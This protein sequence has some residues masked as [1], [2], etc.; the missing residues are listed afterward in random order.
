V[1]DIFNEPLIETKNQNTRRAATLGVPAI[2]VLFTMFVGWWLSGGTAISLDVPLTN[3]GDGLLILIMIKRVIEGSWLFHSNLMGAPF[4]SNLYDYPIPD[5]GSLFVLKWLG[6]I[7]GS[8]GAALNVYYVLGFPLN[9]LSAYIVLRKLNVSA[10]LSFAGGFIFT[11]L[12][13]HFERLG[14]LF[15]TWYFVAPIFVWYAFKIYR[16]GHTGWGESPHSV[17]LHIKNAVVL[18]V[19][20]CFGVYYAFF[21]VLTFITAGMM[22]YFQTRS[23]NAI[24]GTALAV[25]IVT[26]G[27]I[28]NVTPNLIDRYQNGVNRE[29][30]TRLPVEAEV[31][32]LKIVQLLLPRE[33]HRFAP[34]AKVTAKYSST[35]P[36]V[37]ENRTASLGFIGSIGFVALLLGFF[38]PKVRQDARFFFLAAITLSL[39]LFCTVGGFS[40]L[41]AVLISPM[42]RAWNRVSVFVAFTSIAATMLLIQQS[43]AR[44]W[45][46]RHFVL[47]P[48]AVA[49]TLCLFALWDQTTPPCVPCLRAAS[50]GF[51]SD[52]LFVA[53][54]EKQVP[55]GSAIYQ[56]PYVAFPEVPPVNQLGNYDPGREF[57]GSTTLKWSWGGVKGRAG[58]MFFRA[59]STTPMK[60][61]IEVAR[62]LCF[63]GVTVDRRGYADGGVAVEAQLLQILGKPPVLTGANKQ[64]IFFDLIDDKHTSCTLKQGISSE[65]IMARAG[66]IADESGVK[67]H[68]TLADGINFSHDGTPSFLASMNGLSVVE[69]WGRWTDAS[70]DPVLSMRFA[71]PLPPRFI[72]HLRTRGFG[73]NA[74][75]PAQVVVGNEI[76]TFTPTVQPGDYS[77]SF[78]NSKGTDLITIKP[79]DP[80]SPND[81]GVSADGRKL[82][83][84]MDTLSIETLK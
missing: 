4:G 1:T 41:F 57:L 73:P 37:N 24:Y 31:Y 65:E 56:L 47:V 77:L 72:L 17:K 48:A 83:L 9:A 70:V 51:R 45:A 5:S 52:E 8:A 7:F 25:A 66:L 44:E 71:Q 32:G 39:L 54:I 18:L 80:I 34:L 33:G 29:A 40:A 82:G 69:S 46:R 11:V 21:G 10:L 53:D 62:R 36:L 2:L 75:R 14:H 67:Y 20:S 58:D 23:L 6:R 12:P 27:I 3:D 19:L 74:G 55:K 22:R 60:Q 15:Y 59:L 26:F 84:G 76:Q 78:T 16:G 43:L 49:G 81:L 79:A 68:A 64:Q 38:A 28:A 35:F 42:I 30:A 13:F 61:Q 50:N 63:S